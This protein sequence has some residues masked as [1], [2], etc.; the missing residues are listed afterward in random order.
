MEDRD[1]DITET[2][3]E[4]TG[5]GVKLPALLHVPPEPKGCVVF[6]HG[7]GSGH[8]SPRNIFVARV[9]NRAGFA[10][11]LFDLLTPEE[12]QPGHEA[13]F[14]IDRLTRRVLTALE[15][16]KLDPEVGALPVGLF[17]ASTGAAAAIRA[18]VQTPVTCVVSR[19]GRPDLAGVEMLAR[20]RCPTLFLVGS[21]D[22][23]VL[24]LNQRA[25]EEM[26]CIKKLVVVPGAT[27]LFEE[28]GT[29]DI[30][31]Q[32]AQQWFSAYLALPAAATAGVVTG[33]RASKPALPRR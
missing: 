7:A 1:T 14:D 16:L 15:W 30:A 11:L 13:R 6:V 8:S 20:L 9:L 26:S 21:N 33:V 19:S 29:L 5:M 12:D 10:T 32:G 2:R 24:A 17:G 22:D 27:H 31:A 28:V 3:C 23:L 4:V 25:L 18:A